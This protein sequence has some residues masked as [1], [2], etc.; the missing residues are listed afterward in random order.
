MAKRK[1]QKEYNDIQNPTQKT[2]DR[3][4][5]TRLKSGGC[6]GRVDS[7]C[8]SSGTSCVT[9]VTKLDDIV[10]C[11]LAEIKISTAYIISPHRLSEGYGV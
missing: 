4:T 11:Q 7:S 5:Q 9:F 3:A 8:F 2:K 10:Q 6:F 1:G